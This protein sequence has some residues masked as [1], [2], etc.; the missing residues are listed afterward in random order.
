[1]I[2]KSDFKK[3]FYY[4][5]QILTFKSCYQILAFKSCYQILALKV[6]IKY[7]LSNIG[8]QKL[9][10]NIGFRKLSLKI[11][12]YNTLSIKNSELKVNIYPNKIIKKHNKY[13]IVW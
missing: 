2:F 5:H 10:S 13:V 9:L 12:F 8:F 6:A 1:M 3:L 11:S 7:W 4:Y